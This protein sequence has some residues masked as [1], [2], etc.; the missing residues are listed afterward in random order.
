MIKRLKLLNQFN[1]V[2]DCLRN[3][4]SPFCD[5]VV[6]FA[7]FN[8]PSN[9]ICGRPQKN[10]VYR[11]SKCVLISFVSSYALGYNKGINLDYFLLKNTPSLTYYSQRSFRD[12]SVLFSFSFIQF[13][14]LSSATEKSAEN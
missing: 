3:M 5:V 4:T 1:A 10:V 13:I 7:H 12:T 9:K 11:S 6:S 8:D 2:L 14:V